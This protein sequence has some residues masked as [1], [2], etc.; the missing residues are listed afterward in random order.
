MNK[1]DVIENASF[2]KRIAEEESDELVSYFVETHQWQQLRDGEVDV[3]YG[4][5]GA[6][7]SAIYSLLSSR[8]EEFRSRGII[9]VQ[10]ENPRGALAFKDLVDNPPSSEEEFRGFWKLFLLCLI[11]SYLDHSD[12]R[13]SEA[14]KVVDALAQ[15]NLIPTPITIKALL[16]GSLDYAKRLSIEPQVT[17]KEESGVPI[18]SG[19]ITLKEPSSAQAQLGFTSV[20]SLLALADS[21]LKGAGKKVWLAIDRL[22]VAFA[23]STELE[24]NALRALFRVYI[25]IRPFE[26]FSLKIFLRDDIWRRIIEKGFREA[27]HITRTITISWNEQSLLN[28]VIRRALHNQSIRDFYSV[29]AA[30]VLSSTETQSELLRRMFPDQVDSGPSKPTTFDWMLSRTSDAGGR[31]APRELIHLL[32]ATRSAQLKL[33]EIGNP[34]PSGE[35]LFGRNALKAA[36]PEVSKV[37]FEQTLC[38]EFPEYKSRLLKLEGKKTEQTAETLAEIWNVDDSRALEIAEKLVEIGFFQR[39]QTKGKLSFWVPFLY[40]EALNMVQG[41]E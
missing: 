40:R 11:G 13:T 35:N 29:T 36:L 10:A 25:D 5:K 18:F 23:E 33:L 17:F 28:L 31:T 26:N 7:K 34:E 3:I 19:K 32:N 24:T 39:K 12:V 4:A 6:G 2:G 37:R 1:K 16:R 9:V 15:A 8:R 41:A 30:E 38:A 22:D 14:R 27:S 21:A 20:D